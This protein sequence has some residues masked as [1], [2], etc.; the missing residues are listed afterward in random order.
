MP[1]V[2]WKDPINRPV[3]PM[4]LG[5]KVLLEF[6]IEDVVEYIDWNPFFQVGICASCWG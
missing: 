1:Q 3:K 2:D 4:L 6:P 5:N